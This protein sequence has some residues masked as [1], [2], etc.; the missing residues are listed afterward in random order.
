MEPQQSQSVTSFIHSDQAYLVWERKKKKKRNYIRQDL[1][2]AT[3]IT[4]CHLVG[5]LPVKS[6]TWPQMNHFLSCKTCSHLCHDLQSP[7]MV[8]AYMIS[9]SKPKV[10]VFYCWLTNLTSRNN[11]HLLSCRSSSKKSGDKVLSSWIKK[12]QIE[13]LVLVAILG[14]SLE[15]LSKCIR[16]LGEELGNLW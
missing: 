13:F 9:S 15:M 8:L 5:W 10:L 11:N 14:W 7:I 12:T 1:Q 4:E 16:L 2:K 6:V 3:R